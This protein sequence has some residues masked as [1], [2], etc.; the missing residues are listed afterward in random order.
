MSKTLSDLP[1]DLH[2]LI[3]SHD[4]EKIQLKKE[5]EKLKTRVRLLQCLLW[6]ARHDSD[7]DDSDEE[8]EGEGE[9][10]E[11]DLNK[12]TVPELRKKLRDAGIIGFIK[13]NKPK[14]VEY[15][16]LQGVRAWFRLRKNGH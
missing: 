4:E 10:E 13:S 12:F 11:I 5:N 8:S 1:S 3:L 6:E 14:L 7:E 16:S 2:Q 9:E 15:L